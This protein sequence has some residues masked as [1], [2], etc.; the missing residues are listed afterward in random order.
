MGH[1]LPASLYYMEKLIL[2]SKLDPNEHRKESAA[3]SPSQFTE[4]D[5]LLTEFKD[6]FV[7]LRDYLLCG[8]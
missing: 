7:V 5:R 1:V 4:L 3:P 2:V 6:I 8:R